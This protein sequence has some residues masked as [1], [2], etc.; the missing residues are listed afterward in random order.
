MKSI[1]LLLLFTFLFINGCDSNETHSPPQITVSKGILILNE[2]L[3]G[4]NNSTLSYYDSEQKNVSQRVYRNANNG[5]PLGD[6]GSDIA[7]ID[8]LILVSVDNSNKVEVLRKSDFS[9]HGFID[10]GAG[11]SPRS[12]AV[13]DQNRAFATSTY[14]NAVYEF[15]PAA[16]TVTDTI[17]VGDKPEGMAISNNK[18]YVANSGFGGD[19]TLSVIDL[20]TNKESKRITVGLNPRFVY[21]SQK[22]NIIVVCSGSYENGLGAV[23]KI[24]P[25]SDTIL[26]SLQIPGNP[27]KGTVFGAE[28]FLVITGSGVQLLTLTNLAVKTNDFI[29]GMDVNSSLGLIY[30]I[31]YDFL[32]ETIYCSNPKDYQQNGEVAAFDKNGTEQFRIEC[33]I[34][35]GSIE[36]L[37]GTR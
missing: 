4:Q 2:G 24:D 32:T 19:T 20:L 16:L 28:E 30:T 15:N 31:F 33:G 11:G 29:A 36:N 13:V 37:T 5:T 1:V 3:F 26:D 17:P 18:L 34:N 8:S 35:P 22:N 6:T 14:G 27:Q 12:I 21:V 7:L 23:Y 9:S 25:I 10:L